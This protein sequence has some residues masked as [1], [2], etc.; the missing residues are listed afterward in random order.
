MLLDMLIL[1][2]WEKNEAHIKK[3]EDQLRDLDSEVEQQ[4]KAYNDKIKEMKYVDLMDKQDKEQ[5]TKE[6]E[7]PQRPLCPPC[8]MTKCIKAGMRHPGDPIVSKQT[9]DPEF[10]SKHSQH[11]S[12]DG[13]HSSP[14]D[15]KP[16]GDVHHFRRSSR[17][18]KQA[19]LLPLAYIDDDS[20]EDDSINNDSIHNGIIGPDME[21]LKG[22]KEGDGDTINDVSNET[23]SLSSEVISYENILFFLLYF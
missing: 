14:N 18:A 20:I 1:F 17:I 15:D 3:Q 11:S 22:S 6:F 13:E 10:L 9:K 2:E 7:R 23:A 4:Q 5:A 12:T 8:R 21:D 19:P 16:D